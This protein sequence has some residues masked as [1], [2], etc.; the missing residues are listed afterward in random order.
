[1]DDLFLQLAE[2]EGEEPAPEGRDLLDRVK[3]FF[4]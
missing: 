2:M 3:D 1:M 4:A